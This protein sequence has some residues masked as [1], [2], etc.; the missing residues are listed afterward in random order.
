MTDVWYKHD[1]SFSFGCASSLLNLKEQPS[2]FSR[3]SCSL[4]I[5]SCSS[6]RIARSNASVD[7]PFLSSISVYLFSLFCKSPQMR[8]IVGN[9]YEGVTNKLLHSSVCCI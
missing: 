1:P 6:D 8:K 7:F 4:F 5:N 2:S 9:I 3:R